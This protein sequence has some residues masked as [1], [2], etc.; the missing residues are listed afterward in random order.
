MSGNAVLAAC[1]ALRERIAAVAADLLETAV[2]RVSIDL[3][4]FRDCGAPGNSLPLIQ[5]LGE[6]SARGVSLQELATFRAPTG[7]RWR[8]EPGWRGRVV[9]DF[10]Y[11]CHG[12]D[13]EVDRDTGQLRVLRY[14]AGHDVGRAINPQTVRGQIEG[15]VVMG[16]GQALSE[17]VV[18]DQAQNLTGS[19]AQ[20]LIPTAV[21]AA[22][23]DSVIIES[24]DGLGPFNSRGAGETPVAPPTPAIAAALQSATGSQ[25]LQT[26][27][28][29]RADRDRAPCRLSLDDS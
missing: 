7:K 16:L 25:F 20:Y 3:D 14:V 8:A 18:F 23:V 9:P 10:T 27:V 29:G 17:Q 13:I 26:P 6:C 15:G 19:F 24:G 5:V 22:E 2:D 4:G 1:R 12:V 28:H 21:E 11:G